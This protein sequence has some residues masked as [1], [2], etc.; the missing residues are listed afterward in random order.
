MESPPNET[1]IMELSLN[2]IEIILKK[3]PPVKI[4]AHPRSK[5]NAV[6][7]IQTKH[8][9]HEFYFVTLNRPTEPRDYKDYNEKTGFKSH[10]YPDGGL[11]DEI[12]LIEKA[13]T[14]TSCDEMCT[15]CHPNIECDY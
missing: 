3:Y 15:L 4:S 12:K 10:C 13:F 8:L 1:E 11:F 9:S 7:Y 14:P 2:E 6:L 5:N